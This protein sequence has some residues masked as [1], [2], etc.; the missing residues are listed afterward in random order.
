MKHFGNKLLTMLLL[1][2][3]FSCST[4][5]QEKVGLHIFFDEQMKIPDYDDDFFQTLKLANFNTIL[6]DE[7]LIRIEDDIE[8]F[9]KQIYF[10]GFYVIVKVSLDNVDI[11]RLVAYPI[12]GIIIDDMGQS[13]VLQ[14]RYKVIEG[15]FLEANKFYSIRENRPYLKKV[16]ALSAIT[17]SDK[18][19]KIYYSQNNLLFV[20]S[21]LDGFLIL[22][23]QYQLDIFFKNF[24]TYF[25]TLQL[26]KEAKESVKL[27]NFY[28]TYENDELLMKKVLTIWGNLSGDL[29]FVNKLDNKF[30][31]FDTSFFSRDYLAFILQNHSFNIKPK[32]VVIKDNNFTMI[33]KVG[34]NLRLVLI[35]FAT[36]PWNFSYNVSKNSD[37]RNFNS[38]KPSVKIVDTTLQYTIKENDLEIFYHKN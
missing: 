33:L 2:M 27:L 6:L 18:L 23:R 3:L 13:V 9:L 31:S 36:T 7:E 16:L 8:N 5:K 20:D 24:S 28:K 38:S 29:L 34:K 11:R 17:D 32:K 21:M 15:F 10:H 26:K 22:L 1:F 37:W 19:K 14:D 30:F 12:D 25:S 4:N 35:N